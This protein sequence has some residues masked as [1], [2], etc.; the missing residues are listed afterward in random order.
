VGSAVNDTVQQV[1]AALSVAVLGSVLT[2][3]YRSAMPEGTSGA[4]RDSIGDALAIAGATGDAGLATAAK[5]AFVE[6]ISTTSIV[7]VV[8]G[9]A[10]ALVAVTVLRPKPKADATSAPTADP[11]PAEAV[12]VR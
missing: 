7:G 8:G 4:A 5:G 12:S 6:A 11:A 3:V 2:A 10:A 9:V 1:G